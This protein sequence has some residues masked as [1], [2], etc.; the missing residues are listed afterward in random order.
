V[1]R[2]ADRVVLAPY[3]LSAAVH[4]RRDLAEAR[5]K[6]AEELPAVEFLLAEQLGRHPLLL[7]VVE[8]RVRETTDQGAVS[9]VPRFGRGRGDFP[10]AGLPP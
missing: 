3:F 10:P 8:E 6:L 7:E 4:V 5:G 9:V 1:G 2:G